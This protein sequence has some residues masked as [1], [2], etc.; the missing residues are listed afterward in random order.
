MAARSPFSRPGNRVR[1]SAITVVGGARYDNQFF[2][3]DVGVVEVTYSGAGNASFSGL[4]AGP[5]T[6]YVRRMTFVLVG[7]GA[8]NINFWKDDAFSAI[9][10]RFMFP[11]TTFRFDTS[12]SRPAVTWVWLP[13]YRYWVLESHTPAGYGITVT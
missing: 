7:P 8:G 3:A 2:A 10:N 6:T 9:P 12:G 4:D 13:T 5:A 1:S 11:Y